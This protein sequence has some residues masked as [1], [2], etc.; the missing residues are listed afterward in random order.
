MKNKSKV[1]EIIKN[2]ITIKNVVVQ[3]LFIMLLIFN[4]G[5]LLCFIRSNIIC[6]LLVL[7]IICGGVYIF[8]KKIFQYKRI[9]FKKAY[10]ILIVIGI[11]LRIG[12]L[13][14]N[15][16]DITNKYGDYTT[17]YNSAVSISNGTELNVEYIAMFPYLFG[18][19]SILGLFFKIFGFSMVNVT[20]FNILIDLIGCYFINRFLNTAY[21]K[22][23]ARIG[24]VFWIL[25]PFNI[26][27]CVVPAPII[28]VNTSIICCLYVFSLLLKNVNNWKKSIIISIILGLVLGL[29]NSFRPI[30]IVFIIAIFLYFIYMIIN[31]TDLFKRL[32]I[33]FLIIATCFLGFNKLNSHVISLSLNHEIAT[34]ASGW[35]IY[36]GSNYETSG[37]WESDPRFSEFLSSDDFEPNK[38][39]EF[40]LKEGINRYKENGF[41]NAVLFV[42]KAYVLGAGIDDPT[43]S[44][45]N[46]I[47]N[48]E[49]KNNIIMTIILRLYYCLM[50]L[51]CVL[52]YKHKKEEDNN[53]IYIILLSLGFFTSNLLVEVAARYFL[54]IM[55]PLYIISI[56]SIVR[57]YDDKIK[58]YK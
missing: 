56:I 54:P 9:N 57:L 3:F 5:L 12:L 50:L 21:N 8:R 13:F 36:I 26:L 18:Y 7:C 38:V 19:V 29:A 2:N 16:T 51:L 25:N 44:S 6:G 17:F 41:K 15:Y 49:E 47:V 32:T 46:Q 23:I 33:C 55:V 53:I 22:R 37:Q 28:I 11:L 24:T 34:S 31:K 45:F 35:T 27:W 14:L 30:M 58:N 20:I 1:S 40:Y 10:I 42:K 39:H 52:F 48:P 4:V 43:I